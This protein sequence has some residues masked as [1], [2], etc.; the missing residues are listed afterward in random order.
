[1]TQH[2]KSSRAF[3]LLLGSWSQ[4]RAS[5]LKF[6]IV[7]PRT[8]FIV[9]MAKFHHPQNSSL[10][11]TGARSRIRP[12]SLSLRR[13]KTFDYARPFSVV[14]LNDPSNDFGRW[15]YL[16]ILQDMWSLF[17]I[18]DISWTGDFVR[19]DHGKYFNVLI[20]FTLCTPLHL[21]KYV[22]CGST[23]MHWLINHRHDQ[24]VAHSKLHLQTYV[25]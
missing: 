25:Q 12:M 21:G 2:R 14:A 13:E 23:S 8:P 15:G 24:E 16:E 1:M 19:W 17:W 7:T 11:L 4:G 18:G 10:T 20:L 5:F 3:C 6:P 9:F 22:V